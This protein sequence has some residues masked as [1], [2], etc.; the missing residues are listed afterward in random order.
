M[1]EL[2]DVLGYGQQNLLNQVIGI[3]VL[4]VD[5]NWQGCLQRGHVLRWAKF[6]DVHQRYRGVVLPE[7]RELELS[8]L[9]QRK[10]DL[11]TAQDLSR[12]FRDEVVQGAIVQYEQDR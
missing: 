6:I 8:E 2:A 3:G 4:L 11:R 7:V 12:Y 10:A 5:L 1:V 9:I